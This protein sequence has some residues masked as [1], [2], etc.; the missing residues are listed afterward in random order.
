[1]PIGMRG[2]SQIPLKL[3]IGLG[4]AAMDAVA[5]RKTL[6]S[7]TPPNYVRDHYAEEGFFFVDPNTLRPADVPTV[8]DRLPRFCSRSA[9]PRA[10]SRGAALVDPA[11]FMLQQGLRAASFAQPASRSPRHK[12]RRTLFIGSNRAGHR[13][14]R[15]QPFTLRQAQK[16]SWLSRVGG[17]VPG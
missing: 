10:E 11:W 12:R 5:V 1:M 2:R 7:G 13:Q 9:Q 16:L 6:E 4:I 15:T 8:F 17:W 3:A 14:H